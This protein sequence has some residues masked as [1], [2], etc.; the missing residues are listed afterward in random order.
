MQHLN[1]FQ[2]M[3]RYLVNVMSENKK[4]AAEENIIGYKKKVPINT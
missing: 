2:K 3:F 1:T 4:Q